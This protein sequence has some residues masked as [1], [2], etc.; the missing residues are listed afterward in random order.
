M[1]RVFVDSLYWIAIIH[2]R[3][4][5][6]QC[7]RLGLDPARDDRVTIH[8]DPRTVRWV[9][10]QPTPLYFDGDDAAGGNHS[11]FDER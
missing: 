3:D 10:T 1:N 4:Q 6:H 11:S 2:R 7:R 9:Q 5:W 8:S